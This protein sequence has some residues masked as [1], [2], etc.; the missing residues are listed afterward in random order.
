MNAASSARRPRHGL[1][2]LVHS[3]V[4]AL[5]RSYAD[6]NCVRGLVH[7]IGPGGTPSSA[8]EHPLLDRWRP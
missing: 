8:A 2:T 4:N 3:E 7:E 6:K 1:E 5:E